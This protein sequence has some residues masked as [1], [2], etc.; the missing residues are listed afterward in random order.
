MSQ[1]M[2]LLQGFAIN[3][4]ISVFL[5]SVWLLMIVIGVDIL[6]DCDSLRYLELN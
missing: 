2:G 1:L 3:G 4:R 6:G 5:T